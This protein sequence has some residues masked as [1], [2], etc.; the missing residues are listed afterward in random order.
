MMV[1]LA[2]SQVLLARSVGGFDPRFLYAA[3]TLTLVAA[4]FGLRDVVSGRLALRQLGAS[5][6]S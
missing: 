1:S 4:G 6:S 5:T 2:A 3:V